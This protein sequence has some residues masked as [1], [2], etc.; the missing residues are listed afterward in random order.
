MLRTSLI[1][2]ILKTFESQQVT[3]LLNPWT[4]VSPLPDSQNCLYVRGTGGGR[5]LLYGLCENINEE[6]GFLAQWIHSPKT[7]LVK[8]ITKN[9]CLKMPTKFR[10]PL[11]TE[12]CDLDNNQ[13]KFVL[14]RHKSQQIRLQSASLLEFTRIFEAIFENCI[15]ELAL[16]VLFII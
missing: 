1:F 10:E 9:L 2:A 12:Q 6:S 5:K 4:Q 7:G 16:Y 3:S 11:K 14:T 13:Q 15:F 8:M